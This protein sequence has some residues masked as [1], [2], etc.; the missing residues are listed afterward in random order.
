MPLPKYLL[1]H[2]DAKLSDSEIEQVTRWARSE[3]QRLKVA[4]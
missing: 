3:R 2:P 4:P 1:L